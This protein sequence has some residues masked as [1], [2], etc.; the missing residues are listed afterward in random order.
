LTIGED[1]A[2]DTLTVSA[3]YSGVEDSVNVEVFKAFYVSGGGKA[4]NTG[5]TKDTPFAALSEAYDA[6]LADPLRKRIV[7]LSNLIEEGLVTLDRTDKTVTGADVILIEG[8][9]A[10]G[11]DPREIKRSVGVNNSVLQ[12][13]G[14]AD[15]TFKNIKVNGI[16][17]ETSS[18]NRAILV[19]GSGTK[20]VFGSGAVAT[21]KNKGNGN[22]TGTNGSGIAVNGGGTLVMDEGSAV[23]GC[24]ADSGAGAVFVS[25]SGSSFE[26]KKGS[27]VDWNTTIS[28]G[29]VAVYNHA[30][31]TMS[32]GEIS[33]NTATNNTGG[34]VFLMNSATFEMS[35]GKISDNTALTSQGGGIFAD[36]SSNLLITDGRISGNTAKSD[37]GGIAL[38]EKATF[39]MSGGEI[40]DN[41]AFTGAGGGIV[42]GGGNISIIMKGG[43]IIKNTA[44]TDGGGIHM[45]GSFTMSDGE[46]SD[47]KALTATG[48]GISTTSNSSITM[49]GGK[50]SGNTAKTDGGGI[51]VYKISFT[52]EGGEISG[53]TSTENVGG[54]VFLSNH[55]ETKFTMTGGVIY[56]S[57]EGDLSN[58][59][60]AGSDKGAALYKGPNAQILEPADVT[61]TTEAT[62]D[63][64]SNS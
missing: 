54:G 40:S 60:T 53:N 8:E 39:E 14:G 10:E 19:T 31:F 64:R 32:G 50:I 42:T 37:G 22:I 49:K 52:M 11:E 25:G 46:I 61:G 36:S 47:N 3:A 9:S 4:G 7:V 43:R 38:F 26:M 55:A 15:I 13:Q 56:G 33:H 45:S 18:N 20:V 27:R 57:D 6:A 2:S 30:S 24:A 16:I 35:G 59:T 5:R 23:T 48:G 62:I 17:S 51:E 12:I 63:K 41:T 58:K 1:E 44:K 34:G 28:G 21:G 29:G